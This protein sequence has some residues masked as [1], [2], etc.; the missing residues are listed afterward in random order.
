MLRLPN[1]P[2]RSKKFLEQDDFQHRI[3]SVHKII[4]EHLLEFGFV[5]E[6]QHLFKK[7]I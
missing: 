7:E 2:Y 5:S 3:N 1:S 4:D 6:K